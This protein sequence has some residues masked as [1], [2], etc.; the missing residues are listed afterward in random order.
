MVKGK[1]VSFI[2]PMLIV[3]AMIDCTPN[4]NGDKRPIVAITQIATHPA[5]DEVR[6]GLVEGLKRRGYE[7]GKTVTIVFKNANGDPS[8]TLPIAEEFARQSP[9]VIVPIS[10][11]SALSTAKATKTIPIVFSGVTD[12]V[13]TGLVMNLDHPGGNITGVSDQWPFEAQVEAFLRVFPTA[14]RIGM[15][16]T[17]GDD[18][19]KIGV[20]AMSALS[21]K[22]GFELRL[23]AVSQAADIYPSAVALL[24]NVDTIYTGIDHL[25]LENLDT[26]VKAAREARKPLFGGESG[27]VEKGGVLALSINMTSFGDLTAELVAKVLSGQK[28]GEIPVAVVT[29]GDLLVNKTIAAQFGLDLISLQSAGAKFVGEK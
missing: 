14:H 1:L 5:L 13:G 16:Y 24:R 26:L 25:I 15:L 4:R 9:A 8:L 20:E 21:R 19:S 17:R 12:P 28:P 3:L 27:S 29:N 10:T 6:A 2:A 11:A 18:V 22:L 7:D 23:S